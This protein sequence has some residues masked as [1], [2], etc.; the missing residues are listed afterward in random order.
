MKFVHHLT[1]NSKNASNLREN[2]LLC[3]SNVSYF[4]SINW[5]EVMSKRTQKDSGEER[6]TANVET[7]DEFGLAKQRKDS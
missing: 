4:D 1:R 7:D 5:S 3:L 6:V 2:H